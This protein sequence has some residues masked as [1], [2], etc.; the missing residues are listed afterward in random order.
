MT[1]DPFLPADNDARALA[2]R[3]LTETRHGALGVLRDGLPFVTRIALA[4][5][6]ASLVTFVSDLAPHTALLRKHPQA[7]LLIGETGKDDPLAHPRL[8]LQVTVRPLE[9]TGRAQHLYLT[10]QPK[11]QLYIGFS[12]FHLFRLVPTEAHLN[13]GFGKAYRLSPADLEA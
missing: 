10:H 5:D 13:A 2:R 4:P 3:L 1:K 11:A 8:T 6:G 12:D 9:K 7:S